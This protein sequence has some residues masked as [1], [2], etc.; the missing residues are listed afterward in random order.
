MIVW[1]FYHNAH[2]CSHK[3]SH[4]GTEIPLPHVSRLPFVFKYKPVLTFL[5]SNEFLKAYRE[6]FSD[7]TPTITRTLTPTVARINTNHKRFLITW[8]P[9]TRVPWVQ[10]PRKYSSL[11][12]RT[13]RPKLWQ[14]LDTLLPS[15]VLRYFHIPIVH[16]VYLQTFCITIV[17]SF[18]WDLQSSQE[19]L[20]TMLTRNFSGV[21]KVYYS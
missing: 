12:P 11:G 14:G 13:A 7:P 19:N 1:T 8:H 21:N 20:K 9:S 15:Q 3:C 6:Y 5:L 18:S 17:S 2:A 16:L 10:T 4:E